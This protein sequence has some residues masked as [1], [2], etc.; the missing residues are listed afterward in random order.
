M[1][2]RDFLFDVDLL[3]LARRLGFELVEVPT[4]WIDQAG[5]KVRA[6]GDTMRML[7]S[8]VR[9]WIHHRTMPVE[10]GRATACRPPPDSPTMAGTS[11]SARPDVALIAPYPPRGERH[12]G[13]SGVAS[14]TANLAHAL[15]DRGLRVTVVAPAVDGDPAALHRRRGRRSPGVPR[16][17][18]GRCRRRCGRSGDGS[19]GRPPPVRAV[20]VRRRGVAARAP[21]ALGRARWA[22]GESSLVTT[23]HQVVDPAADRPRLHPPAPRRRS[24]PG[25]PRRDR[26]R[27]GRRRAGQ[28]GDDR[29]RGR[30]S[31]GSSR[32]RR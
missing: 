6:L 32:R 20:P 2:S 24:G 3:V 30:R 10:P 8:A 18:G 13:H 17:A 1:S 21:A 9:L 5:S 27:A 7:A 12:G 16:S 14:Y 29:P 25:R 23:M 26:R 19:A 4:V 28:R 22:L 11:M 15:A 31:A